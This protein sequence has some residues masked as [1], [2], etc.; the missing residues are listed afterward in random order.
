MDTFFSKFSST[1]QWFRN[2]LIL[3]VCI[4]IGLF[5]QW[6]I[7][8]I[9]KLDNKRKSTDLKEQLLKHLKKPATFFLPLLFVY[10]SFTFLELQLF[11]QKI[12]EAFIVIN[13]AW[14]LI[15]FLNALEELVKQKFEIGGNHRAKERKVLTQLRFIKS[16]SFVVIITLAVA[17]ILWNIPAARK[18]GNTILTS[19][20]II[21][22]IAGVAAQKSIA[23]LITGFQIAF[24]QPIK[25]DDEVVIEG[26]FGTV[27]DITLTYVV[28]KTWDWRRQVIPLNYFN[29]KPFVNWSF[30]STDIIGTVFLYV[31][32]T[33]PV[34]A[35]RKELMTVLN[36]QPKWDK[37]I[38]NLLVTKTNQ[39]A[40]ELR[41][42]FSAKNASDVWNLRCS[43][44][45]QLIG[46]IQDK[47]PDSLPKLRK[48]EIAQTN[49]YEA[50]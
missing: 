38:A 14:I 39:K 44:R 4:G 18:I 25:I 3:S 17:A 8:K 24:A 6:I 27:E 23:N 37:N 2:I 5:V 48:V 10:G 26:E 49:I 15:A 36:K 22:I 16:I 41:V 31:D 32:Y 12:I 7:F 9:L 28:I 33:F 42:T 1:D 50:S 20:G 45:E 47:Y 30:N 19:A 29:D 43:V 35:L 11:W 13:L 21:G 40:M 46:F 34:E